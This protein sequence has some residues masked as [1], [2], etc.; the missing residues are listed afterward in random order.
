MKKIVIVGGGFGGV[1]AAKTLE[2]LAATTGGLEIVL[3]NKD[4][5]HVMMTSLHEIAGGRVEKEAVQY[6]LKE[7]FQT[8]KV[9]L[10]IDLVKSID[11]EQR[12]LTLEKQGVLG[13]DYLILATGSKPAYFS[14]EGAKEHSL[15]LWSVN[16]AV[17]VRRYITEAF[18]SAAGIADV[19]A[20]KAKLSFFVAGG[21]FTGVELAGELGEWKPKL[22]KH[23]G[24]DPKEV[25]IRLVEALPKIL[26]NL[27]DPLIDK[28][29][30]KLNALGIDVLTNAKILKVK[31]NSVYLSGD[32]LFDGKLIWCAGIEGNT[33]NEG[34]SIVS[35]K[36][37]RIEADE[38]LRNAKYP[39]VY[40]VGDT[41]YFEENGKPLPQTVETAMQTAE[42]AA[43]NIVASIENRALTKFQSNLHGSMVSIGNRYGVAKIMGRQLTGIPAIFMKQMINVHYLHGIAGMRFLKKYMKEQFIDPHYEKTT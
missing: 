34:L 39:E 28:A 3:V 42:A 4:P 8:G 20:R 32:R 10:A 21:G 7:I 1:T 13:Y 36:K 14:I 11:F 43:K 5:N 23:Y 2:K 31:S 24:I 9:K 35:N 15:P 6:P 22:C 17:D 12:E 16:D 19:Q 27:P 33:L 40:C 25:S 26:I 29:V 38:Y 30:A 18:Q 41:V 37:F